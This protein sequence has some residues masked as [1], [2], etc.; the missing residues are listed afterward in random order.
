MLLSLML[1]YTFCK[2]LILKQCYMLQ[3]YST[4][5]K[6]CQNEVVSKCS[7]HHS[8]LSKQFMVPNTLF[9]K[10]HNFITLLNFLPYSSYKSTT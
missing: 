6:V 7:Q 4:C 9:F 1:R 8:K 3:C 5:M 10:T 2:S